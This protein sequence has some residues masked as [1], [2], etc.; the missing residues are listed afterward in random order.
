MRVLIYIEPHPIRGSQTMFNDVARRFL[1]LLESATPD[2]DIRMYATSALV[3]AVGK[4]AVA[5]VAKRVIRA[6]PEE[7]AHFETRLV[8]WETDGVPAW[9]SLMAGGEVADEY[10]GVLRRIWS[11][12]PY[13]VIIHWGENG[14]VT[15]FL[16]ERPVTRIAMEL[17]CT[18]PPFL[19]TVVLDPFGTNGS[20]VVPK[21]SVDDLRA[22]V[23]NNPMSA[24]EAVYG[25]SANLEAIPYEQQ[26]SP[27]E[28]GDLTTRILGADRKI[29]FLPLQ[30][31]D[32]ANLLRFSPYDTVE[33]VVLDAVPK[34]ANA[35]YL[36][37]IKTHPGA[38]SRLQ[39]RAAFALARAALRPWSDAVVWVDSLSTSYTNAQLTALADLVVTV[40][41]SVGFEALYFD[42]VVSVLG[43]AVYKPTGLF[44]DL[45]TA[46]DPSFDLASYHDG[47]GLLR[48]FMLGG[49]LAEDGVRGNR[50]AFQNIVLTIDA[51]RRRFGNN[52][53]AIA[54]S[55]YRA[56]S[57]SREHQVQRRMVMGSSVPGAAEFGIPAPAS[58]L[59][60]GTHQNSTAV[61]QNEFTVPAR[62]LL[63]VLQA[64]DGD[65][66]RTEL[67]AAFADVRSAEKL[68]R[69]AG[70]VDEAFYLTS[71]RD[72][73]KAEEDPVFHWTRYG[74]REGRRPRADMSIA[75]LE[76][77]AEAL[78]QA[79]VALLE[80]DD[81]A[82]FPMDE[83][84][85]AR[86]RAS[87]AALRDGLGGQRSRIAVVANLHY[88]NLVAEILGQLA[89]IDEPFDLIVTMPD[90]GNRQIIELVRA[91]YPK[92][93]FFAATDRGRDV[94]PFLDVLPEIL[95]HNYDAILHLRTEAGLFEDGRLRRELGE[96]WR[97][98]A[99][100]ALIGS[101]ERVASILG[102]FRSNPAVSQ[103]GPAPHYLSLTHHPH[104][105]SGHLAASIL[106]DGSSGGYFAGAMF[107][108]RPETLRPLVERD[109]V[110][111]RSFPQSDRA[112]GGSGEQL[113]ERLF[114]QA[115]SINGGATFGAPVEP[116]E[117]LVADLR[118]S[119]AS[120]QVHLESALRDRRSTNA[121]PYRR[122]LAW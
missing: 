80:D 38:K 62:R 12:F 54:E 39:S 98:E 65:S 45:T 55:M 2:F 64:A 109:K 69:V 4:D 47:V 117:P 34:L 43:D 27:L 63:A 56:F 89:N 79:A 21:L 96:V 35:G 122:A 85:D 86:R 113:L 52:P 44:P 41:S 116:S 82:R 37:V 115:A 105:N 84:S 68:V 71:Y 74:V 33:D 101:R 111:S 91:A 30:L 104:Q 14:A 58:E 17:G 99:L 102:S 16:E 32:D 26:Y 72:V 31:H 83:E 53:V 23:G 8:D 28:A 108:V 6:T 49:Y 19:P 57:P 106:S 5:G 42:K 24:A 94:G 50:T 114:G 51:A 73:A 87:V 120:L 77:L 59:A 100:S 107:W 93:Q 92:A 119:E 88:R 118:P 76:D 25:Y 11:M 78:T 70:I 110:D 60:I 66:L 15:R 81:A 103:V 46:L 20:A 48:R 61:P 3:G 90:W 112:A 9:L 18:R 22:I 13:D 97:T 121:G 7:E 67:H 40:N 1:P 75:S 36:T 10:V 29:A 95:E